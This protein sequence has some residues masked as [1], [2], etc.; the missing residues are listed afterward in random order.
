M[1]NYRPTDERR[2]GRPTREQAAAIA[3]S[4]LVG[5]RA[6]F[7]GQGYA[8]AS[9]D[10]IAAAVG[11]SKLTIYRRYPSKEALLYA[12][13]DRDLAAL[14]RLLD[15][16]AL[17]DLKP[18]D[19]L[20]RTA[21]ALFDFSIDPEH[22]RFSSLLMAESIHNPRLRE[23]FADWEA[24]TSA[25]VVAC[26]VAAQQAGDLAGDDPKA[27]SLI[28]RELMDGIAKRLRYGMIASPTPEEAA[29]FFDQR[30]HFFLHGAASNAP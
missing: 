20:R 23:R 15:D 1:E 28:L 29:A 25:P 21:R 12:M 19:A 14:G 5:A 27:L 10:D 3:E 8:A 26:I 13:V 11:V 24:L 9:M 6:V 18:V 4:V 16:R 2:P 30:W 7:C 17:L 22:I